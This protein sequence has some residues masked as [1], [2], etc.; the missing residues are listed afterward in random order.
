MGIASIPL[1]RQSSAIPVAT[2]REGRWKETL[3]VNGAAHVIATNTE[4]LLTE[5]TSITGPEGLSAAFEVV[6]G[7]QVME[8]ARP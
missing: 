1:A 8:I 6:G 5:P 4:N 3:R 7:A 2:V